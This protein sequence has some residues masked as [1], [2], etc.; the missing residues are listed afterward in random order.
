MC[1]GIFQDSP[2]YIYNI[3]SIL[4]LQRTLGVEMEETVTLKDILV[5]LKKRF[6]TI[7]FITLFSVAC[8]GIFTF[9][10]LTPIY[11][12]STQLLVNQT[13]T[14][15][16]QFNYSDIQTNLQLINTYNVIIKSPAILDLVR[17][18]LQLSM[19]TE[20]LNDKIS[21]DS[22]QNSQVL[23]IFV[24]DNKPEMAVNI[25]N[26][27]A[28]IFQREVSTI[29]NVDN[30]TILA[31]AVMKDRPI[32]IKPQPILYLSLSFVIGVVL[33]FGIVLLIEYFDS[34][35]KTELD[36]EKT[37]D[38]PLLGVVASIG[39][40]EEIRLQKELK[41]QVKLRTDGFD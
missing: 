21:V 35:V 33:A 19:T 23:T 32:P 24:E 7:F 34:S 25:A 27:T 1:L 10:V 15:E 5:I 20:E 6:W 18:E 11:Q 16:I 17:E 14:Q 4:S 2:I 41:K 12:T 3:F 30:V 9:Y 40:Q 36:I 22:E 26:K 31:K 8:C 39:K 28:E 37:L 38:L 13:R 29:M